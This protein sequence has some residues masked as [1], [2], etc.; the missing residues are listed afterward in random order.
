MADIS[1]RLEFTKGRAYDPSDINSEVGSR[2]TYKPVSLTRR[3][4]IES[5]DATS[6][7]HV[8]L[9]LAFESS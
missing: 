2:V 6:G 5:S 7:S 1:R 9:F 3:K 8:S 4:A